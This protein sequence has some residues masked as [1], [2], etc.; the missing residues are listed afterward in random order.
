M[1]QGVR[2]LFSEKSIGISEYEIRRRKMRDFKFDQRNLTFE[3]ECNNIEAVI[4]TVKQWI[5]VMDKRECE[6][7]IALLQKCLR[8]IYQNTDPSTGFS[9]GPPV[10]RMLHFLNLPDQALQ[11]I[12]IQYSFIPFYT[13]IFSMLV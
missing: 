13:N 5:H 1:C 2:T 9:L 8:Q 3:M 6:T 4:L 7:E 10:M 12:S 11:V